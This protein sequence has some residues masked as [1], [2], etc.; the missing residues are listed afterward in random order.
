MEK[1]SH[2]VMKNLLSALV[3]GAEIVELV[4]V[5]HK[6]LRGC[7]QNPPFRFEKGTRIDFL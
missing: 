4:D 1:L 3:R 2:L 7:H 6:N 5:I